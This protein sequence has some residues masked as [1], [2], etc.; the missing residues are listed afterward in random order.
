MVFEFKPSLACFLFPHKFQYIKKN[1]THDL[2]ERLPK[3]I[4]FEFFIN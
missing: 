1:D 3:I 2:I 4:T